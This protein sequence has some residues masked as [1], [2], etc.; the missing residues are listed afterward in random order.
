MMDRKRLVEAGDDPI[1]AD[2]T[3]SKTPLGTATEALLV[4]LTRGLGMGAGVSETH[5]LAACFAVTGV[6]LA[7]RQLTLAREYVSAPRPIAPSSPTGA[8]SCGRS[9]PSSPGRTAHCR[10]K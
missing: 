5:R 9:N 8:R 6:D 1:V 7:A 4:A 3:A 2:Y 10:S